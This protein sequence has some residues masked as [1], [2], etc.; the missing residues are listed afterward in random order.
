M[1][2][3]WLD[4]AKDAASKASEAARKGAEQAKDTSQ[5]VMLRRKLDGAAEELAGYGY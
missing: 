5:K 2:N 4:K 3:G 1:G